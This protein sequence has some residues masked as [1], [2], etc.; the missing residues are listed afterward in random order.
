MNNGEK[1]DKRYRFEQE[2]NLKAI[3]NKD[4]KKKKVS[5]TSVVKKQEKERDKI[6]LKMRN[7]SRL[8]ACITRR[9]LKLNDNSKA[10]HDMIQAMAIVQ[11]RL[12]AIDAGDESAIDVVGDACLQDDL[13]EVATTAKEYAKERFSKPK[14]EMRESGKIPMLLVCMLSADLGA[15]LGESYFEAKEVLNDVQKKGVDKVI[16]M[17]TKTV[18]DAFDLNK[19][20]MDFEELTEVDKAEKKAAENA[21]KSAEKKAERPFE[22]LQEKKSQRKPEKKEKKPIEKLLQKAEPSMLKR[23]K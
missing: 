1:R 22:K 14:R 16:D 20:S 6:I 19:R 2:E 9:N 10:Y 23:K 4:A 21:V 15:S 8:L 5:F 3:K 18:A 12:N 17:V 7:I 13:D 11:K